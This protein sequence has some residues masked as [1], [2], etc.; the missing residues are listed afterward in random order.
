MGYIKILVDFL[1]EKWIFFVKTVNKNEKKSD[2]GIVQ[3][4]TLECDDHPNTVFRPFRKPAV[5][6][7]AA[8]V[9][10]AQSY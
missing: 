1:D 4:G 7:A 10:Q 6:S 2:I 5:I 8:E 9:Y 3:S